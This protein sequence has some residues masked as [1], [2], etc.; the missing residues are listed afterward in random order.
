MTTTPTIPIEPLGKFWNIP[1]VAVP[2]P[3]WCQGEKGHGYELE[4]EDGWEQRH[5]S[6]LFG[7][8]DTE[9]N[10]SSLA[11]WRFGAEEVA[12]PNIELWLDGNAAGP[13]LTAER[14]RL[15]A[16]VLIEAAEWLEAR[17]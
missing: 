2:C 12:P 3:G 7:A 13:E 9:A 1:P 11:T 4:D 17:S 10:V 16:A 8:G 15:V 6:I 14:A 5:H